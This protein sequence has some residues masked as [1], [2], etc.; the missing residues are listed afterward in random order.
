LKINQHKQKKAQKARLRVGATMKLQQIIRRLKAGKGKLQAHN[1]VQRWLARKRIPLTQPLGFS[2]I[3]D[4]FYEPIPNVKYIR[5]HYSDE[6]RELP[7]FRDDPSWAGDIASIVEPYIAE[8]LASQ[9][10]EKHSKNW[11]YVGWDAAYYYCLI[12]STKPKSI[13]EIG[14]GFSTLIAGAALERNVADGFPGELVSIDP[15]FRGDNNT[16]CTRIIK[17]ELQRIPPEERDNLLR[18]DIFFI[19]SSHIVKWGSDTLSL[20]E[21]W[22]PKVAVNTLVHVHDIFTPYDYPKSWLVRFRR[23]W[24]EQYYFESFIAFNSA[25]KIT[26]PLFY[27]FK[28]GTL[29]RLGETV[30]SPELAAKS[31]QAM[32]LKRV[33]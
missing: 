7:G 28:T 24:N 14:R 13:T 21:A 3:G 4:H 18:A 10:Y 27:L 1:A 20:F 33:E 22:V 16:R 2:I 26:C 15:Y 5:Q 12:R 6:P 29:G 31:G 32:W 30:G 8:Y 25:F 11:F 23:F 19:D 17:T 9:V